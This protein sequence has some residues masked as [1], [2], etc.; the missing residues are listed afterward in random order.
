MKRVA[1]LSD[2]QTSFRRAVHTVLPIVAM[3]KRFDTL[4][5]GLINTACAE[6]ALRFS[7]SGNRF[8]G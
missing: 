2:V 8:V 1:S 3:A 5:T 7:G 4:K 6:A